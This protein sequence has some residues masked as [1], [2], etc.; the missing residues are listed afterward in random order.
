M[1][2]FPFSFT[3]TI[4]IKSIKRLV[5]WEIRNFNQAKW[6]PEEPHKNGQKAQCTKCHKFQAINSY[7]LPVLASFIF[8][9]EEEAECHSRKECER[10]RKKGGQL[11]SLCSNCNCCPL[12]LPLL[13]LLLL[14]CYNIIKYTPSMPHI[15]HRPSTFSNIYWA[16][17]RNL[18]LNNEQQK[19]EIENDIAN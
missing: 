9:E 18:K 6:K 12:L 19:F 2:S 14:C 16:A 5:Q 13:L 11:V 17:A 8:M 4:S 10:E 3:I 1:Q 15:S 7:L